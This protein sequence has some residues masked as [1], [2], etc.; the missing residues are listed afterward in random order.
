MT[1][2][3]EFFE[4]CIEYEYTG[5][6]H[7]LLYMLREGR[8]KPD[9]RVD[10]LDFESVDK[11]KIDQME[12]KNLLGFNLI[13]VFSLKI[14]KDLFVFVFA[15]TKEEAIEFVRKKL[16]KKPLNCHEYWLG[17]ELQ[18][19]NEVISFR[20]MRKEHTSFPAIAGFFKR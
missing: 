4:T 6:A 13:K 18:R 14:D 15:K 1:T 10:Q 5:L 7:C 11:E 16:R 19:G 17:H 8:A 9:D 3:Q 12:R 2:V 20:D